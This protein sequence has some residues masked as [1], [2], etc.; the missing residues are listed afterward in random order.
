ML[1]QRL[2]GCQRMLDA[3]IRGGLVVTPSKVELLDVG[4]RDESFAAIGR[5]GELTGRRV[6]EAKGR[7]VLPG[8]VDPHVHIATRFGAATT[9]DDFATGTIPAAHGGTT[10]IVEF[11]IPR[12]GEAAAAAIARRHREANGQ[13]VV[14]YGFH[15]VV[16]GRRFS[17]SLADLAQLRKDGIGT[18]KV[19]STY[20]DTVGLPIGQIDTVL[21]ECARHGL[22]VLVHCETEGLIREGIAARVAGGDLSPL[23]HA[24]SRTPLAEA[25]SIRT[26]CRL[27]ADAGAPVYIV[28]VSSAMGAAV[29]AERKAAGQ[30]LLGETCTQYLF[31]DES[32]YRRPDA[33]LWVC[34]PPIR[35]QAD[36]TALWRAIQSDTIGMVATDHNCFDREQKG[37]GRDDFRKIPNGLPGIEFR[38]P[39]LV[40]AVLEGRLTWLR[41]AQLAAEGPARA[42]G[43]WPRKGAIAIGADADFT[44]VDPGGATDLS[45][46]HMATDYSPFERVVTRGSVVQTWLRGLCLVRGGEFIGRPG[47]GRY[48]ASVRS[49]EGDQG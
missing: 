34:S 31:L 20:L 7:I 39:L 24:A 37:A 8:G 22:L 47:G 44:I 9:R 35:T 28:H 19:F 2:N 5:P 6:I 46:S 17:E 21:R 27:A 14:D 36:A 38:I 48:L 1:Q 18:V 25:D 26:V 33:E 13:A 23:A 49:R 40:G 10:S 41:F 32:V 15:A 42:M 45:H 16:T 30:Q 11:A 43:L 29:I 3:V 4:I 12:D